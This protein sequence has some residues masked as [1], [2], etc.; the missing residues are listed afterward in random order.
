MLEELKG[1]DLIKIYIDEGSNPDRY[2]KDGPDPQVVKFYDESITKEAIDVGAFEF[3][4]KTVPK[5]LESMFR[6]QKIIPGNI[7]NFLK[8]AIR[9][10]F[11]DAQTSDLDIDIPMLFD[12]LHDKALELLKIGDSES[13]K[14]G[15][16][17]LVSMLQ[18]QPNHVITLYN[19]ACAE[20]L[21]K[22]V[23]EAL[24]ALE[25][26]IENGFSDLEHILSDTDLVNLRNCPGFDALIQKLMSGIKSF[27]E[28]KNESSCQDSKTC[29][30]DSNFSCNE[31]IS[32]CQDQNSCFGCDSSLVDFGEDNAILES[33]NDSQVQ[34]PSNGDPIVLNYDAFDDSFVFVEKNNELDN[35]KVEE[36][37]I[38]VEE[39]KEEIKVEDSFSDLKSKWTEKVDLIKG[40]GFEIDN[41]I[42]ALLLEQNNGDHQQVVNLFLQNSNRI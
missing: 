34:T 13:I 23:N 32:C 3:F 4:G 28:A 26:A 11:L 41:D 6:D 24:Q 10:K 16:D 27:C 8:D 15:R 14:K 33:Y 17:F 7:P 5:C 35:R 37:K 39:K 38:E 31:Q 12:L 29:C 22:N 36:K 1:Q 18:L 42:I 2:F 9:V 30:Q 20:S 21:L 19:L 40:M 25:K